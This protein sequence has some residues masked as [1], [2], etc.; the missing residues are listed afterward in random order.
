[1]K[2]ASNAKMYE[3]DNQVKRLHVIAKRNNWAIRREGASRALKVVPLREDAIKIAKSLYKEGFELVIHRKDGTVKRWL[4][5]VQ[6][7]QL[8]LKK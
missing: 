5:S 6:S 2:K 1:M 8:A 3:A 4:N 7:K